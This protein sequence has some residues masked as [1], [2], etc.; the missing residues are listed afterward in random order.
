MHRTLRRL[1]IVSTTGLVALGAMTAT[2]AQATPTSR[3]AVVDSDRD[4][5]PD[6]WETANHLN[7]RRYDMREDPD[8]DGLGNT[9]EYKLHANPHDPDSDNDGSD[10][11]DERR[12]H[13]RG[14][15]PHAAGR[16]LIHLDAGQV[17]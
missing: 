4:G 17:A 1:V 15:I 2:T 8:H 5:M 13:E 3:T 12:D 10:D 14:R 9:N 7:P 6:R 16:M 11:G